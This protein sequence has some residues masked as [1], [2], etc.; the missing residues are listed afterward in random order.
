MCVQVLKNFTKLNLIH[1]IPFVFENKA[2]TH[3]RHNFIY[4]LDQNI[5]NDI[6]ITRTIYNFT[7]YSWIL[8]ECDITKN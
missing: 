2:M 7:Q 6:V 5:T 8:T 4:F 3:R 1:T